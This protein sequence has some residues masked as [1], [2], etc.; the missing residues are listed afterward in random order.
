MSVEGTSAP[1]LSLAKYLSGD[2]QIIP[3]KPFEAVE[4]RLLV[5]P[6]WQREYVWAASATGEVGVLL[7]DLEDFVTGT[8]DDYLMGSVLLSH[9]PKETHHRLVIDGQQRSLTYSILIMCVL[10]HI[11]NAKLLT[12]QINSSDSAVVKA[13]T[14]K[15][16]AESEL[17]QL[18]NK[19]VSEN[20]AMFMPRISMPHQKANQ[21]LQNIFQWSK[22]PD[23]EE[24]DL[25]LE[26][27]DHWTQTQRNLV[28]VAVWIYE[29]KL[30]T[31]EWI[32]N[33]DLISAMEK[34][35]NGVKFL[36][37]TL[38]SQQEAI[39]IFDRINSRG[40]LLDSGDLIKNRIFQSV[41]SDDDFT[42][43]SNSW[44][45]MNESLA[46]CS[47]KRMREPKF[48]LRALALENQD[49]TPHLTVDSSEPATKKNAPKITYEKLTTY[50]GERLSPEEHHDHKIKRINPFDFADM[51]VSSSAWL[52]KLSNEQN[53]KGKA[54]KELYFSRYLGSVQ[55]YPML[56]AGRHI[57]DFAVLERLARQVHN[58]TAFY[59]L[60]E[61]RTQ[62]F[63]AMVPTWTALIA[64]LGPKAT[65]KELDDIYNKR[66]KVSDS[67][68]DAL[69]LQMR[70]WS[71]KS[72]DKKKIR[73][74]LSQLTRI[75]D[76]VAGRE[77]KESPASYFYT[78]KDT[79]KDTKNSKAW[80]IDHIQPSKGA[81]KDSYVHKIGNLVLLYA[82]HNSLKKAVKPKDKEDVYKDSHL[83]L[84]QSLISINV[85]SE[86]KKV[87]EYLKK[88]GFKGDSWD[89]DSWDE[90][91]MQS[92]ENLY[93]VLL[94]H[95]LTS[96]EL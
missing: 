37:V 33:E 83:K 48:L 14:D 54:L 24:A 12:K 34:I 16:N 50:W 45:E 21:I 93:A 36:Q 55:H 23:G 1:I 89:L 79:K 73:A 56:L 66:I 67:E 7:D 41:E 38:S 74:V 52:Q 6:P 71:Y 28:A 63:E 26:E 59:L 43:I 57:E 18:M 10:K 39:A 82:D 95:H 58:R 92:R 94:K 40:A 22:M 15:I 9:S 17:L 47:L 3:S 90:S 31:Q 53:L 81:G 25:F 85:D 2:G 75:I 80:D 69:I 88:I 70:S 5:I 68:I 49:I 19:S 91:S 4:N 44:G 51:L 84:T 87:D 32:K 35:M 27:K 62:D 8:E 76:Q 78:K 42:Q 11:Q 46:D 64:K 29:K 96:L 61:E 86:R 65:L 30:M 77:D 20:S 60:S 72:P 13:N